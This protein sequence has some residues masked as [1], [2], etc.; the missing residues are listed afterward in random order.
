MKLLAYF[1]FIC[2][3]L[4][5]IVSLDIDISNL[6]INQCETDIFDEN[7]NQIYSFHG[8]HKC[9]NETTYV[10]N[11]LLLKPTIILPTIILN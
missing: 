1:V 3:R 4:K 5:G 9:P 2:L 6:E 10:S 8:T 7:D 11:E